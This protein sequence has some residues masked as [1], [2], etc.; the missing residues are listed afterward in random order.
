MG[1]TRLMNVCF[2][3]QGKNHN[4]LGGDRSKIFRGSRDDWG[5]GSEAAWEL[6]EEL[7]KAFPD[8]VIQI[9]DEC[10]ITVGQFVDIVR[11]RFGLFFQDSYADDGFNYLLNFKDDTLSVRE[12]SG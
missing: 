10:T 7:I 11:T 5:G 12:F 3:I 9:N 6:C 1:Q 8:E 2:E 4:N